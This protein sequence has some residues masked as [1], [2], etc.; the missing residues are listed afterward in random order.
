MSN[1]KDASVPFREHLVELR[2]RII[3]SL[4]VVSITFAVAFNYSKQI[5]DFLSKPMLPY[6]SNGNLVYLNLSGGFFLFFKVALITA[7]V[8]SSPFI[9]YQI[10]MF[11][12]PGLYDNERRF[13]KILIAIA[14]LSFF[15]GFILLYQLILPVFFSFFKRF[16]FDFYEV[17]PKADDY[18]DFVLKFNLYAGVLF[19]IPFGVFILDYAKILTL[20][21]LVEIRP[22][23]VI[24]SFIIAAAMTPPDVVSQ[25]LIA[26]IIL[27]LFELGVLV[28][29]LKHFIFR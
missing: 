20:Q 16:I 4:V 29:R 6:I 5:L 12:A 15:T 23:I 25:L 14:S 28:T 27:I 22:G 10:F 13:I 26:A 7:I 18:L 11:M 21:K 17:F 9:V 3:Y 1:H 2:Q 24:I 19:M 8:I